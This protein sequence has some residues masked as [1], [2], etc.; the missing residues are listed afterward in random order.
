M[1]AFMLQA[2]RYNP[3]CIQLFPIIKIAI[4][5]HYASIK[6][7]I[8]SVSIVHTYSFAWIGAYFEKVDSPSPH[9]QT[10]FV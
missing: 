3:Y 8:S 5:N 6:S 9:K 7:W 10:E 1:L 2:K 4:T